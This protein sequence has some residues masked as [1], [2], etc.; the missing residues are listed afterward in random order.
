MAHRHPMRLQRLGQY[1]GGRRIAGLAGILQILVAVAGA[2]AAEPRTQPNPPPKSGVAAPPPMRGEANLNDEKTTRLNEEIADSLD[3]RFRAQPK[4]PGSVI[5]SENVLAR[6]VK[7]VVVDEMKAWRTQVD[8]AIKRYE[9]STDAESQKAAENLLIGIL[10][11]PDAPVDI[12]RD[13]MKQLALIA[14]DGKFYSRAQQI[15]SQLVS[16]FPLHPDTPSVLLRQGVLYRR[17][18]AN[19]LALS[20]FHA[21]M[22]TVLSLPEKDISGYRSTVLLAQTEI[23]D[24]YFMAG[25]FDRASEYFRRVLKL[26]D[27]DLNEAQ[28]RL[29][30]VKSFF[31]MKDWKNVIVEGQQCVERIALSSQIAEVRFLM[32]EAYKQLGLQREALQQTMALLNAEQ[33]RSSK[34]PANWAYWQKRTGNKLA[35]ELYQQGDYINALLIYQT[36]GKL[37][38]DEEWRSQALY[39]MG[40]IYERLEQNER[41]IAAYRQILAAG[42][43]SVPVASMTAPAGGAGTA[44]ASAAPGLTN[45]PSQKPQ[46]NSPPSG[47]PGAEAGPTGPKASDPKSAEPAPAPSAGLKLIREMAS[48]RLNNLQWD[49][50][51]DQQIRNLSMRATSSGQTTPPPNPEASVGQP[52]GAS[53]TAA[54]PTPP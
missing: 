49:K 11:S 17:V 33:A 25:Q 34:D 27:E 5:E 21:V 16:R 13:C 4:V 41:A 18:G 46:T 3:K 42:S 54:A 14:L 51:V 39:Q 48:W 45:T 10:T 2:A 32:A 24:T 1:F 19:E 50:N 20:K 44:Q 47:G 28:I 43:N 29:K 7:P 38:G 35:N 9:Q 22:S 23:A 12:Q 8:N 15:Y 6:P 37:P 31:E 30:L 36:L 53:P 52:P 26:A 40:L